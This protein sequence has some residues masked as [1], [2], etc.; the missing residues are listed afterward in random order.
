[1]V[2]EM[3]QRLYAHMNKRKKNSGQARK[4]SSSYSGLLRYLQAI[5]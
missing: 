1:M 3:T 2:G 5:E 4:I